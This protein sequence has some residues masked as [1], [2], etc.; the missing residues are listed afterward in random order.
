MVSEHFLTDTARYADIV[1]PATT[2]LEQKDIMFSWG[3]LYLSYNNA[4]IEPLGEAV[5]NTELFR[6]LAKA[7]G[8]EDPSFLPDRRRDD[9]G[10]AG[11]DQSCPAGHYAGGR[12]G[13]GLC[14]AH[15]CS[16][17]TTGRR[18]ATE[19][20]RRLTGKCEFKST[21]TGGGNFVVPL[22]RQGYNGDQDGDAGRPA[23]RT[24]SR[25]TRIRG[26]RP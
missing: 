5:P 21:I 7:M 16:S 14:A 19:I 9:R 10:V 1:L 13:D 18:T 20:F 6:R 2:Q 26:R 15:V 25:R 12:Q 11:L 22:F 4:A 17:R 23:C 8:I 24:T 3:H